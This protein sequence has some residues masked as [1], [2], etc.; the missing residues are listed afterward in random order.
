MN[1][2]IET[3]ITRHAIRKYQ[4]K[5]IEKNILEQILTAGLY[6]PSAGNNQRSRIVV[7]QNKDLN[8]KLGELSRYVEFKGQKVEDVVQSISNDQ[9]SIKDDITIK[10]GFYNAPTVITI[11]TPKMRYTYEDAAMIAENIMLAAHALNIGS[12]YIG[13]ASMV[14]DTDFG[15]EIRKQWKIDDNYVA[16]GY[17]LL[18]YIDGPAPKAK[19]RKDN[20][21]IRVK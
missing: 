17:V 10:D 20:R 6:A 3:M 5:Q 9:P 4:N 7:C 14:F 16:V 19:P 8:K 1:K 2:F 12:C 11:F 15:N 21:I 18:G 13:R